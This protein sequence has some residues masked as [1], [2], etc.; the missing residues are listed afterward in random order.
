[1]ARTLADLSSYL[2]SASSLGREQQQALHPAVPVPGLAPLLTE[3]PRGG[4]AEVSG[5]R[6]SGR[7]AILLHVLA[8]ATW[9]GEVCA[10][11]DTHDQFS[12]HA[13]A[14]AGVVLSQVIWVRGQNRPDNMLR[15]A[16]LLLHAGGFGV[17]VLDL[18]EVA[19]EVWNRMPSSWWYRFQRAAERTPTILLLC[20]ERAQ[21]RA[22][23]QTSI[24][25]TSPSVHWQGNSSFSLLSSLQTLAHLR[26]PAGRP[27]VS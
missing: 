14:A 18:P 17:V 26:K 15:A 3:L 5:P 24:E 20:T 10:F 11:L 7:M 16:D 6:S 2:R 19:P 4:I 1:V 12:P 21:A 27:A 8:Q 22:C 25:L 23:A 9:Q 13:A